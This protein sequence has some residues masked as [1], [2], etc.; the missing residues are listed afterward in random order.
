MQVVE[1]KDEPLVAGLDHAQEPPD[2]AVVPAVRPGLINRHVLN[3]QPGIAKGE[4]EVG[5]EDVGP[6]VFVDGEPRGDDAAFD[7]AAATFG[8]Q[9]RLA[10]PA[11]RDHRRQSLVGRHRPF[12]EPGPVHVSRH[13]LGNGHLLAQQPGEAGIRVELPANRCPVRP[14]FSLVLVHQP[15]SPPPNTGP[16]GRSVA[17]ASRLPTPGICAELT[18]RFVECAKP[19]IR[20]AKLVELGRGRNSSHRKICVV[21]IDNTHSRRASLFSRTDMRGVTVRIENEMAPWHA[22][23]VWPVF[24]SSAGPIREGWGRLPAGRARPKGDAWHGRSPRK[25][26]PGRSSASRRSTAY[27]ANCKSNPIPI[28]SLDLPMMPQ[29]V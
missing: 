3:G 8:E 16:R 21:D 4:G 5:V 9:R 20:A 11:G 23:I 25:S 12:H 27:F 10:E 15:C 2:A 26:D 18:F 6:V 29:R 14:A 28:L 1:R 22:P 7:E 17:P 24:G 19:I 13:P